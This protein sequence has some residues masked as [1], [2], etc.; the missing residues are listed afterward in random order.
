MTRQIS[1]IVVLQT[2]KVVGGVYTL[3]ASPILLWAIARL[4]SASKASSSEVSPLWLLAAPFIYG[5]CAYIVALMTCVSYNIV[6]RFFG[7]VEF[8]TSGENSR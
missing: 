6:A 4:L 1:R 2:A 8:T 5:F 3:L 7:G